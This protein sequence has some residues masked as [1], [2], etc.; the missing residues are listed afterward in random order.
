[1]VFQGENSYN[2]STSDISSWSD[3]T[4]AE[5]ITMYYSIVE[6]GVRCGQSAALLA[7]SGETLI[8]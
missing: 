1:M 6:M 8:F 7:F 3:I 5:A 4:Q 2:L